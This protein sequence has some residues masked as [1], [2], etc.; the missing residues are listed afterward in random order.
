M[1]YLFL[2][3]IAQ[4]S[5]QRGM[6]RYQQIPWQYFCVVPHHHHYYL[7]SSVGFW[8]MICALP[9]N[10]HELLNN[11]IIVLLFSQWRSESDITN[12]PPVKNNMHNYQA[13]SRATHF[14]P[15]AAI[16]NQPSYSYHLFWGVKN[17]AA[18][19]LLLDSSHAPSKNKNPHSLK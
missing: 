1:L 11:I 15:T 2:E 8:G 4:F 12:C 3:A 14:R 17:G 6:L 10:M 7:V 18:C 9:W 5:R 19:L 13:S 16:C